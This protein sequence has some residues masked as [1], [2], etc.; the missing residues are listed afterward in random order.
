MEFRLFSALVHQASGISLHAGKKALLVSRLL[1]R[2]RALGLKSFRAYYDYIMEEGSGSEFTCMLDLISTNKT[3]FFREPRHF[4]FL[5]NH[6]L[7]DLKDQKEIRIWSAGCSSG[8]EPYSIAMTVYDLRRS[9]F[10]VD[11]KILASD[12]STR[13]LTKAR[14]GIYN[15]EN[16][17]DLPP[18][19]VRRHF[20]RERGDNL[21][22]F[23]MKPHLYSMIDFRRINLMDERYPIKSPLD[24][25]FCRNVMIYFNRETQE[26]LIS[27]LYRYLKPG[28]YLFIG[29][30][31][32]VQ[33]M[34]QPFSH[35]T[36]TI[37]RRDA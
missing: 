9:P 1:R 3:E 24:A 37:Y 25:I 2:L 32:G 17:Q 4:E 11:C 30:S 27:K 14:S 29:S 18:E 36:S 6:I 35:V 10:P 26:Q 28:G 5:R 21:G 23:R 13:V 34:K 19:L 8:E 31:E 15:A 7:S 16:L 20:I 33:Q 12:L 22:K